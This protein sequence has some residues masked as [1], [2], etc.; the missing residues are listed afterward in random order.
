[1][2]PELEGMPEL[3]VA[4]AAADRN[5]WNIA[6]DPVYPSC[7][8]QFKAR[9]EASQA[10]GATKSTRGSGFHGESSTSAC[11]PPSPATPQPPSTPTLEW[12]EVDDKVT[13]VMAQLHNLHLETCKRHLGL[14]MESS[15]LEGLVER[16][17][18][19]AVRV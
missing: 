12:Y 8:T 7:L 15:T 1:M 17:L 18:N 9:R 4:L 16:Q 10:S 13:E 2:A 3:S 5:H 6:N 11:E 19:L 14:S